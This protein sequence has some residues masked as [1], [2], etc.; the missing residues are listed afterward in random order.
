[1]GLL[2]PALPQFLALALTLIVAPARADF[3]LW[4]M[5]EVYSNADGTVQFLEL[6]ALTGGQ[7]FMAGH[8]LNVY[9]AAGG[10]HAFTFPTDL[11]GDTTG[12]RMLIATQ[13]FAALGIVTPDYIVPNGF[14]AQGGGLIDFSG[15][16]AW[17]HGALPTDDRSLDRDGSTAVN[18]PRNFSGAQGTVP[19]SSASSLNLQGLWYKSPAESESGWGVNIAHQGDTFFITWFT[20]DTDGSQMWLVGPAVRR[21]TGNNYSGSLF[22][23]TGPAFSAV[24]FNPAMIGVTQVGTVTFSF[25]D[26]SN[27]TFGYTVNGITQSKAITRQIF[28]TPPT[29]VAGGTPGAT[30]NFQ[31]L[32]YAS[33]AESESGWGVNLTHQGNI[34][35]ATWFTYDASGRG[36]W[37]VGPRLERT[38]GNTFAGALFRTTGPAFS[39]NPWNPGGVAAAQVGSATFIFTAADAGTFN[40]TVNGITQTKNLTKQSFGSPATVCR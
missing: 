16:D 2:R 1:M 30:P 15:V 33:P 6:T 5:N 29:C 19:A 40:Y 39:A 26:A 36:M 8:F 32:W 38:T 18:S 25:T 37:I 24:P 12:K 22:R 21:T 9:P 27:G 4:T 28:D 31:D 11:P 35:F 13:G 17:T 23:T 10:T 7:Q 14:F 34:L 20:Y 3:H